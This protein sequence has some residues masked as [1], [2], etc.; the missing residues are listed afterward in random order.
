MVDAAVVTAAVVTRR[1]SS[2]E[3]VGVLDVIGVSV[4]SVGGSLFLSFSFLMSLYP[5]LLY[6]SCQ[7]SFSFFPG[8]SQFSEIESEKFGAKF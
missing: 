1:F 8:N 7:S 3:S 4:F 5:S 2:S 6:L